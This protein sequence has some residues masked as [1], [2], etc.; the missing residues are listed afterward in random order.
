[1]DDFS[2]APYPVLA[3]RKNQVDL[4]R[5]FGERVR[6]IVTDVSDH[7]ALATA[8]AQAVDIDAVVHLAGIAGVR[9]SFSDPARYLRGN[10]EGTANVLSLCHTAGIKKIVFASSSSVYGNSTPLPAHEDAP[11]IAPESPYAASKRAAELLAM[12]WSRKAADTALVALRF[13]TVY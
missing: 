6:V 10:A 2:P 9:P 13:F 8:F 5:E 11:A 4:E 1:V 12:S 3:K 7:A